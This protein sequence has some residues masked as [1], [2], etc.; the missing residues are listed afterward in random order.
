VQT[1]AAKRAHLVVI[2][3]PAWGEAE[4]AALVRA[5]IDGARGA[6]GAV[7]DRYASRA[8]AVLRRILGPSVDVEDLLQETFFQLF[9]DL[10]KLREP[11]KLQSF[12]IGVAIRMARSE[13]RRRRLRRWL[14][15][16]DAGAP[17]DVAGEE[18][19]ADA[20]EAVLRLY[21]LLDGIDD[22]RRMVFVL[23]HIEGLELTEVA[24]A[25]DLSLATTKRHLAKVTARIRASAAKD[26][27][28]AAYVERVTPTPTEAADA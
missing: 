2:R 4:D 26:P 10:P 22:R 20:R 25:L 28:L 5:A 21:A 14:M 7:W 11:D 23:R 16:T 19:D 13:L 6:A 15:L 24:S 3:S 8:R 18:V 9:K 1:R 12:A 27:L 17:P